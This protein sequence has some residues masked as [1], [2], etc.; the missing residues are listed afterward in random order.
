MKSTKE[1]DCEGTIR[2]KN[3]LGQFHNVHGPAII[4]YNGYK[5]WYINGEIYIEEE[6]YK[7][8][9]IKRN[10]KKLKV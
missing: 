8:E 1:I 10:L 2:W 3:D 4:Y 5:R 6:E 9:I 7:H